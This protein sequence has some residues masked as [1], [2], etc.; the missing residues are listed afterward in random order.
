M[1]NLLVLIKFEVWLSYRIDISGARLSFS[2]KKL[3][4]FTDGSLYVEAEM[5]ERS[6]NSDG[7]SLLAQ[8]NIFLNNDSRETQLFN[9]KTVSLSGINN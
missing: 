8:N 7:H 6:F 9:F 4:S 2:R 5:F 1:N 3:K